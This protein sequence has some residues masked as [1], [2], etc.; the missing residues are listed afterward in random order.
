MKR[1]EEQESRAFLRTCFK[2]TGKEDSVVSLFVFTLPG[3]EKAVI[4][5]QIRNTI[6]V[7]G[8]T[9]GVL[10]LNGNFTFQPKTG[11]HWEGWIGWNEFLEEAKRLHSMAYVLES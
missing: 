8:G 1:M 11:A 6:A 2:G 9:V 7:T 10:E 5:Y 3:T 4:D